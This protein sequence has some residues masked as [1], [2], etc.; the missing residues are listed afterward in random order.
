MEEITLQAEPRVPGRHQ[1]RVL[2][3]A[4]HV[5]A[6]VYG[7]GVAPQPIAVNAKDLHKALHGTGLL[8]LQIGDQAPIQVLA[9]EIQRHPV[10]RHLLHIDFQAVSMTETLRLHVPVIHEG[11]ALALTNADVVLVRNLDTVEV[12]CLPQDIP[13]H[14]SANLS[15]LQTVEDAIYVKDLAVPPGVEIITDPDHVVFSLTLARAAAE[16]EEAPE[17]VEAGEVEVVAKGKA[18]A[19]EE[20]AE[21]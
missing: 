13:N 11:T 17:A 15:G 21:D 3:N 16:E 10:K 20:E 12:E 2:R 19:A 4:D 18:R 6:V 9:R 1:V 14:L 5:P 8:A 7:P